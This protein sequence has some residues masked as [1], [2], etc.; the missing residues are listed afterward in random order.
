M[1]NGTPSYSYARAVMNL[2]KLLPML[3]PTEFEPAQMELAQSLSNQTPEFEAF[4][5]GI[6]SHLDAVITLLRQGNTEKALEVLYEH[7]LYHPSFDGDGSHPGN[8]GEAV[9]GMFGLDEKIVNQEF[10]ASRGIT[11]IMDLE[12]YVRDPQR[13]QG[14]E[15]QKAA[16][17]ADLARRLKA[18]SEL[19]FMVQA[20]VESIEGLYSF[21]D[22][23][24]HLADQHAIDKKRDLPLYDDEY[25]RHPAYAWLQAELGCESFAEF[26]DAIRYRAQTTVVREEKDW[27]VLD[28]SDVPFDAKALR[29]VYDKSLEEGDE[30]S[31]PRRF[32]LDLGIGHD[33]VV[34]ELS[35]PVTSP[36]A[37]VI[38][39]WA[40]SVL[41]QAR[42]KFPDEDL[43]VG[44]VM[45][46]QGWH[47]LGSH[48]ARLH[49]DGREAH[50][51]ATCT[52]AG[53]G[54]STIV[55]LDVAQEKLAEYP[56]AFFYI[57]EKRQNGQL[58]VDRY[59]TST[60]EHPVATIVIEP[61]EY[62]QPKP[63]H[64]FINTG[65]R[66]Q[67]A[68]PG[69]QGQ[70]HASPPLSE[71][72]RI[73]RRLTLFAYL[74]PRPE[75]SAAINDANTP[76]PSNDG[77]RY[78]TAR[79]GRPD[80]GNEQ[81]PKLFD[82][83]GFDS[84]EAA[85]DHYREGLVG[86]DWQI[87]KRLVDWFDRGVILP[88][89][90]LLGDEDKKDLLQL[91]ALLK[92]GAS[93]RFARV[94]QG[95]G[96]HGNLL[97]AA[98]SVQKRFFPP[99]RPFSVAG[100]PLTM[101]LENTLPKLDQAIRR[102]V[103]GALRTLEGLDYGEQ[104]PLA[105]VRDLLSPGEHLGYIQSLLTLAEDVEIRVPN[106]RELQ[107]LRQ[108]DHLGA[109]DIMVGGQ[110]T[111]YF[112][113]FGQ[114]H[115]SVT[116]TLVHEL[117]H[118]Y[119]AR[120]IPPTVT[121]GPD[122]ESSNF[123]YSLE[124][125][126]L[127]ALIEATE[128]GLFERLKSV[129]PSDREALMSIVRTLLDEKQALELEMH[130]AWVERNPQ[131]R[132]M[133]DRRRWQIETEIHDLL[134]KADGYGLPKEIFNL[135]RNIDVGA[136]L[137]WDYIYATLLPDNKPRSEDHDPALA[138][139]ER[140]GQ[141]LDVIDDDALLP[142]LFAYDPDDRNNHRY[143]LADDRR[144]I[145]T[146]FW[147]LREFKSG[148]KLDKGAYL[149]LPNLNGMQRLDMTY[150]SHYDAVV[151]LLRSGDTVDFGPVE[152]QLGRFVGQNQ[153]SLVFVVDQ[154]DGN[155]V[156]TDVRIRIAFAGG[157]DGHFV[158]G[159]Q[160]LKRFVEQYRGN[161]AHIITHD[162]DFFRYVIFDASQ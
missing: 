15:S 52:I 124:D 11:T 25:R 48:G 61:D 75:T 41:D 104:I 102:R 64:T 54:E 149:Y 81:V 144:S 31:R 113:P 157:S 51:I 91:Q 122:D 38:R 37:S 114:S 83:M 145:P 159:R 93:R 117:A 4:L 161:A 42:A 143:R 134:V 140:I 86:D 121:P 133:S 108:G 65:K 43:V 40:L 156:N 49:V 78:M 30:E 126:F 23:Q 19:V 72:N 131:S 28:T 34:E 53:T 58:I 119:Y 148:F 94:F 90:Q 33:R 46:A 150:L 22:T 7:L 14:G 45:F 73:D 3:D 153:S 132:K 62:L 89:K 39:Q 27:A 6:G 18:R 85:L 92:S 128:P 105:V 142:S 120:K 29:K 99:E 2:Q 160:A 82:M 103:E 8:V 146:Q 12:A 127:A 97:Q 96:S 1:V 17:Q 100:Q 21:A 109:H 139:A 13:F 129:G 66:R 32:T 95:G 123:D 20:A 56:T 88:L 87:F 74:I 125:A 106:R 107:N 35:A 152:V 63:G 101:A 60:T 10:F 79:P 154:M 158:G 55:L 44:Q 137:Y 130:Y 141:R 116:A 59:S 98:L 80:G 84:T 67:D 138:V 147:S 110:S 69:A 68:V 136:A 57:R 76:A 115:V 47:T 70:F 36:T 5:A 155:E 9:S 24:E 118:G 135:L 50:V 16:L 162:Q 112:D 151:A 77:S 71:G 26:V 111:I